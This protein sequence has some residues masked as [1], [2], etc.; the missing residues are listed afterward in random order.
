MYDY[1]SQMKDL[2]ETGLYLLISI[3]IGSGL[4]AFVL[5]TPPKIGMLIFGIVLSIGIL[6][7]FCFILLLINGFIKYSTVKGGYSFEDYL[8]G[9]D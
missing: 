1:K 2:K 7:G 4:L 6:V 5:L 9:R 3:L 8:N